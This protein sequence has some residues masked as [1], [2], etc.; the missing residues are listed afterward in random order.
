M[1][2]TTAPDPRR[3]ALWAAA[4]GWHVIPLS[5]GTK[6]PMR[7]CAR[8]SSGTKERPNPRY[9]QHDGHGCECIEVGRPCHGVLAATA[10]PERITAW[11]ARMP[12][13]GVG[14]AAGPS[15]LVILDI[16]CHDGQPPENPA[17]LLPGVDLP[18]DL[19]PGSI[20]D[21]RD[22]LALLCEARRA[23]YPEG[24]PT[25]TVRTPSG[26]VH[27]WFRAPAGTT[28][29][30]LV[31]ALG[32]QLDVRAGSS[33][34]VA[35][36]TATRAGRYTLQGDCRTV[37][38]LPVW[39]ARD[40]DRTGHRVRPERPRVVLPWRTRCS[41]GSGYVAAAVRDE[42]RAVAEAASGTRNDTLNRAA[43]SLGTLI[44][45]AG[46]D[47]AQVTDALLDAAHHAGLPEKEAQAAIRSGPSAGARQPRTL[48]AAA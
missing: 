25:F 46:L 7:G 32:W 27:L 24:T 17:E 42:L 16:D 4:Q 15:G 14:I 48:G 20:H 28:W 12:A 18:D 44:T 1:S 26:G 45:P 2:T 36:G 3:V 41:V 40:L 11:W 31:G 38:E 37:A 33:Y 43:F 5:P 9:V 34:A 21:G 30:P 23:R 22:V 6:V 13:A 35:P 29:R 39:L 10:D 19:A 47:R 8:C